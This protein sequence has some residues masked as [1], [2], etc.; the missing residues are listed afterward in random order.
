MNQRELPLRVAFR[1]AAVRFVEK[2]GHAS[3]LVKSVVRVHDRGA[4]IRRL[5][6]PRDW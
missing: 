6:G 2:H 5:R 3:K 4:G 1:E